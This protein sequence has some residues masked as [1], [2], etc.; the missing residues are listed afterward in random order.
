[1]TN[2]LALQLE[3]LADGK[4]RAIVFKIDTDSGAASVHHI[5]E[6]NGT[7]QHDRHAMRC[8]IRDHASDCVHV[9]VWSGDEKGAIRIGNHWCVPVLDFSHLWR[10]AWLL[11]DYPENELARLAI[12]PEPQ[13]EHPSTVYTTAGSDYATLGVYRSLQGA[14]D[15]FMR[16]GAKNGGKP[17]FT[18]V[19]ALKLWEVKL[20][21]K[22]EV[23]AT[24]LGYIAH[25]N[26]L[27]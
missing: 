25:F 16:L 5:F 7:D 4:L 13:P 18:Y 22:H 19:E 20:P 3:V 1:M 6:T 8:L 15:F 24:C 14:Q 27:D 26:L 23:Q 2:H 11:R 21:K 10:K 17:T 12:Q 9:R